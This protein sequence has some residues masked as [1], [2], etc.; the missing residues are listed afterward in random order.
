MILSCKTVKNV[1]SLY[2]NNKQMFEVQYMNHDI[3]IKS[4][5]ELLRD[6][7]DLELLYLIQSLL[8]TAES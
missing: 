8:T 5:I 4:I 1:L 7:K 3:L 2:C 6:C